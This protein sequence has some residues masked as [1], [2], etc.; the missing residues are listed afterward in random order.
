MAFHVPGAVV[1]IVE[2]F[3][4]A[5]LNLASARNRLTGCN[6]ARKRARIYPRRTPLL[7]DAARHREGLGVT[8]LGQGQVLPAAKARRVNALYMAMSNQNNLRQGPVSCPPS[9]LGL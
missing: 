4:R 6:T 5:H 3:D 8:A 7:S 2:L 9:L 1:D